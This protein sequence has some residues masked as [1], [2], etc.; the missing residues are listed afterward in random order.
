MKWA[1]VIL[2]FILPATVQ[3][4]EYKVKDRCMGSGIYAMVV[5]YNDQYYVVETPQYFQPGWRIRDLLGI[6]IGGSHTLYYSD[7]GG[8][9]QSTEVKVLSRMQWKYAGYPGARAI[10]RTITQRAYF[11]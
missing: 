9:Y 6:G 4:Q 11:R 3:A 7:S 10:C 1:L 8:A 5:E 2:I